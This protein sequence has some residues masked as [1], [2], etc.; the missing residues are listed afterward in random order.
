[1]QVLTIECPYCKGDAVFMTSSAHVYR[2]DYGPIYDCR[3]CDAY[4][5]AYADGTSKGTPANKELRA[6]RRQAHNAFDPLW[7]GVSDRRGART[8]LYCRL[9]AVMKVPASNAHIG[10]FNLEQCEHLLELI[11]QGVFK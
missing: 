11:N 3:A 1:M 9:A 4:V 2:Q 8:K 6:A 5:G 10:H 7:L